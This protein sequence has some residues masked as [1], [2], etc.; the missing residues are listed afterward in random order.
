MNGCYFELV[1]MQYID[2][3]RI[4]QKP[5]LVYEIYQ[6]VLLVICCL[7]FCLDCTVSLFLC[8]FTVSILAN[9]GVRM[10]FEVATYRKA[11]PNLK[12]PPTKKHD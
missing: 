2:L 10:R 3:L 12:Q 5:V 8:K 1:Y 11:I 7:A 9:I 6:Y 4:S